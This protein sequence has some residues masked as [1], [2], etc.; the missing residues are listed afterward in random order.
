MSGNMAGKSVA[1]MTFDPSTKADNSKKL[2]NPNAREDSETVTGD[3]PQK[4][5]IG[6]GK[7]PAAPFGSQGRNF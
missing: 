3:N 7:K 6:G 4:A 2:M 1:D 5:W